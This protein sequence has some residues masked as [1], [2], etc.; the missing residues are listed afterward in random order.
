MQA[1]KPRKILAPLQIGPAI[2]SHSHFR[3]RFNIDIL[4]S[5]GYVSLYEVLR[6]DRN[7]AMLGAD[8]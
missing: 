7:A 1:V 8:N 2:L 6:F 3:S 5:L 4:N